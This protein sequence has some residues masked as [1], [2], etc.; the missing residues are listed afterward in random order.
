MS[1]IHEIGQNYNCP[2]IHPSQ[3]NNG[4]FKA[5]GEIKIELLPRYV[6]ISCDG[7]LIFIPIEDLPAAFKALQQCM[8]EINE[9]NSL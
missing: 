8:H 3:C 9:R 2:C 4:C 6:E 7:R 1:E 5:P